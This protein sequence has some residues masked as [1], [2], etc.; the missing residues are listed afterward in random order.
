MYLLVGNPSAQSGRNLERIERAKAQ[1]YLHGLS[2]EFL[3]TLPGGKT[4]GAVAT[5]IRSGKYKAVV[6]MGG[7]G[8]FKEVATGLI[9]SGVAIPLGM[10]PTGT[11][12]DQ[13]R[14]FGLSAAAD[15]LDHNVAVIAA[16]YQSPLD[17]GRITARDEAGQV[18]GT[19]WFFDSAGWGFSPW[20]LKLRNSDRELVGML[21]L[22]RELY[23]DQ[24]V[25]AGAAVQ[26][27]LRTYVEE[28]KFEAAVTLAD[29]TEHLFTNLT[30][31]VVKNTKYYA[32]AWV[33]DP[34]SSPEDGQMELVPLSGRT[35]WL[36][37]AVANVE[38]PIPLPTEEV[39]ELAD[40]VGMKLAPGPVYRS[41]SFQIRLH[42]RPGSPGV[43]AQLDGEEWVG[44]WSFD[45][46]VRRHALRL[47]I[48]AP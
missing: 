35:E 24:L 28:R 6:A 40:F 1:F 3:P 33:F 36:R 18:V 43:D 14:S 11:A 23:R 42:E 16:N 29:G 9:H 34:T 5:A 38:L 2:Q 46:E 12:N 41:S 10:L 39:N 44:G 15:A 27:F 13:G 19:D 48:P 26:A 8:T 20:V 45:V 21:P 47:I 31:I 17:A 32:G 37:R 22:V 25:Y 4:A 30:D 7:D